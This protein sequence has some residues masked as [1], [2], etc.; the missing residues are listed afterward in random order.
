M[1]TEK[2]KNIVIDCDGVLY[3]T[4]ALSVKEIVAAA[5]SVYREELGITGEEQQFI[6]AKTIEEKHLGL[7]NYIKEMCNYKNYDFTEFCNHIVER[8]N[9]S[10]IQSDKNLWRALVGAAGQ[11]NVSVFT[12]NSRPHLEKVLEKVF[13]KSCADLKKYGIKAYDISTTEHNGYF[14]PK[15]HERGFEF[16][17][18]RTGMNAGGTLLFDDAPVNI[19]KALETGMQGILITPENTLI[20]ELNKLN[21]NKFEKT[22]TYE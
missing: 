7:F 6:S 4:S 18:K 13:D 14:Y 2:I 15:Q 20:K 10:R 9:F 17:L 1:Q 16:F 22:K 8:T 12:N 3:P 21:T 5:K 19:E 11:Y